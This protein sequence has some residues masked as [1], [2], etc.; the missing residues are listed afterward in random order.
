MSTV[1]LEPLFHL[2]RRETSIHRSKPKP[3]P[4]FFLT[5]SSNLKFNASFTFHQPRVPLSSALPASI[6][7]TPIIDSLHCSDTFFSNTFPIIRTEKVSVL[8]LNFL[9]FPSIY[10]H[11]CIHLYIFLCQVLFS[12]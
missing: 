2:R 5:C 12:M 3:L 1:S 4:P 6:T 8:N 10:M 9:I 7:D 11:P